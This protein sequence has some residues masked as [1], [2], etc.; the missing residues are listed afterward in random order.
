M[1]SSSTKGDSLSIFLVDLICP[2]VLSMLTQSAGSSN[3]VYLVTG[4]EME[5]GQ[6]ILSENTK[7][8]LAEAKCVALL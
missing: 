3:S 5:V 1:F 4:G 6:N 2:V 8:Q 7:L